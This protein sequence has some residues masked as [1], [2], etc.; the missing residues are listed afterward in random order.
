M[1]GQD[2]QTRGHDGGATPRE[3]VQA[4]A[5]VREALDD[6]A[7]LDGVRQAMA[8]TEPPVP[9]KQIQAQERARSAARRV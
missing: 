3:S 1:S 2:E 5:R 6:P 8:E 9:L 7:L 4:P